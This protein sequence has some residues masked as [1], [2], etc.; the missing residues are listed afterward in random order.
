MTGPMSARKRQSAMPAIDRWKQRSQVLQLELYAIYYAVKDPRVPWFAKVTAGCAIAYQ[1][2]PIQLIPD[3]IPM[4][5]F[6]D[7]FLALA[8]AAALVRRITPP[9]VLAECR[10]QAE[11]ALIVVTS[12]TQRR[13]AARAIL[14]GVL[15]VWLIGA[16]VVSIMVARLVLSIR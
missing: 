7:N 14:V 12:Q 4:L 8:L 15:A 1:F 13:L 16:I 3:W 2:S 11:A 6:A 5:G 10:E 9:A